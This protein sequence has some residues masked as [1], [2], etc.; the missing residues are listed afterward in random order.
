MFENGGKACQSDSLISLSVLPGE[1][2]DGCLV[3]SFV[4][5]S[6]P[7]TVLGCFSLRNTWGVERSIRYPPGTCGAL[8]R[9]CA[10]Q[11]L[12]GSSQGRDLPQRTNFVSVEPSQQQSGSTTTNQPEVEPKKKSSPHRF[13]DKR[14]RPAS[15]PLTS[16]IRSARPYFR[17]SSFPSFS[18]LIPGHIH[19]HHLWRP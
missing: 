16:G 18:K 6:V 1:F 10:G 4:A 12:A 19:H 2:I 14:L 17:N 5:F 3:V 7:C 11:E 15:R 9:V 8:V 13:C